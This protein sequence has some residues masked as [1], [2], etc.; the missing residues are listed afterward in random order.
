MSRRSFTRG[1]RVF[2][3]AFALCLALLPAAQAQTSSATLTGRAVDADGSAL[4]GVTVTATETNTGFSR[5]TVTGSDGSFRLAA[6]PVGDYTVTAELQGFATVQVENVHL[7]VASTRSIE[8]SMRAASIEESI[9]VTTEAP[10][11]DTTPAIGTVV[12][13]QEL[14][15]LPLNGRQF[16]NVAVLAPGTQL[17]YNA[18]PTKPG[19][20]TIAL[21][22]GI[23]RN[24]NFLVDGGDNT[25]DTIGGALQN[26]NLD[27]VEEFKIQTSQY[28]AEYGRSSGGVLSVVTKTGTNEFHGSVY[29]F[30]RR[31]D[32][33]GKTETERLAGNPKS[34]YKRDQYGAT[35][36][37]PIVRDRA[38]FFGTYEKLKRDGQYTIATGG[39][40]PAFDGDVIAIP[41]EDELGTAKAT[42]NL[43]ASQYLQVRYGFQKNSDFYGASP[44]TLP[45]A[46][47]SL[48][49]KYESILGSHTAQIGSD[50]LNEFLFQYT[51]FDNAILE[52]SNDPALVFPSGV[53]SGQNQNT[54]QT[55]L[56]TKYQYKDD[57][58]FSRSLGGR[59]HDFKAG[60]QYVHEPTLGGSFTSGTAGVFT[61]LTDD[62]NGPVRDITQTAGASNFDS[63]VNQY[64]AYFQDDWSFS[65]RLTL[66]LG[67]RYDLNT[68]IGGLELDQSSNRACQFLS[69]QTTYNEYYLNDFKGWNCKGEK[70]D[71]NW[72]PRLGFSWDLSGDGRRVVRGGVGRFYD[73]PYTNATVL[74]P[75]IEV[76]SNFGQIYGLTNAT[77]IRNPDGS[78]FHPGQPLPPGGALPPGAPAAVINVASPKQ[79]TPYSDQ[80]SLGYSWQVNDHLGLSAD[81]IWA[82]YRDIP[83]RFRYNSKLD[84]NGNPQAG[85][86]FPTTIFATNA[87]MWMGDGEASYK[88]LNL[89]VRYRQQKFEL[90]GF[91]TLSEAEGNVLAGADEFRLGATSF[92]SDYQSDR[93]IDSRNP[94]CDRCFGP[95]YTD[96]RHKLTFG[97]IYNAPWGIKTAAFFRYRSAQPY[98]LLASTATGGFR[99]VNGDGFSGDIEPSAPHVNSER[100]DS[101]QQLDIRVSKDFVFGGDFGIE[102]LAEMFNVFDEKNPAVFD[103]FGAAHAYAGDPLQGEQRL[104]QFGARVH[105]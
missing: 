26:Y 100:G 67:L 37:G 18:D 49:N 73:F 78:F 82:E 81:A 97:A 21:N 15:T 51:T 104:W 9:T 34:P 46:L 79:A 7:N 103:R 17:A 61:M 80:V 64:A 33:N 62:P 50:N 47:G 92:Q 36:G 40:F 77:G 11:I 93:S 101:F 24:V 16:A 12:S 94:K 39:A 102:L 28:K 35:L 32:W 95:L 3:T 42:L 27:A 19:Q 53:L 99:D 84:A 22:G 54:P 14:E 59:R 74:F 83:Y 87:R 5:N 65:D 43:T 68:G 88:G 55:T 76:Q 98:N 66:N 69:T 75:A 23:G 71:D 56:Q 91:Y 85:F 45:S 29:E 105:F 72:A 52:L 60:A 13:Q 90:Q 41:F 31:D 96:A 25:D 1:W 30:A 58:S 20:L 63:P 44:A 38:H 8:I 57:F 2:V 10:L 48:T 6:L 89:S 4:P 86:R 70:D